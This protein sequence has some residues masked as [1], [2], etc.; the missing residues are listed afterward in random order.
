MKVL[1]IRLISVLVICGCTPSGRQEN[2]TSGAV[3]ETG[4]PAVAQSAAPAAEGVKAAYEIAVIPKGLA[5][6]FWLTVKAGAEEAAKEF[7]AHITWIGP[8]KET[9]IAQQINIVEDMITKK[10]DAIVMAACDKDA[11]VDAIQQAATAKIP[12]VTIDSGVES[13][14]PI[15]FVATDNIA[16]AKSAARE[17]AKLIGNEGK[18]GLIP[19]VPGA[20]TSVLREDGFK[21]GL[22]EFPNVELAVTLYCHSDVAKGMAATQDMMTTFPDL[23]GIF[24]ANEPGALGAVQAIKAANKA[25]QIKL[26]AFDAAEEEISALKEGVIQAL[27]VQNPFQMGYLGVKSAI[28]H[29]QGR[30]VEKRIDTGVTVVTMENFNQPEIQKLLYPVKQ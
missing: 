7:N 10:V 9:E 13:D 4:P 1:L 22:K 30:P 23:K 20:A 6:L 25:G 21:E 17:L 19:F 24:A 29:I 26:V 15:S 16:G 18:V 11:L 5:H 2:V 27:I 12:V 28:D 3:P 8:A 14:V